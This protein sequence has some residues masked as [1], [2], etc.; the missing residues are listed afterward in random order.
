MSQSHTAAGDKAPWFQI[1][2]L[3]TYKILQIRFLGKTQIFV[4]RL[5]DVNIIA[6]D[7]PNTLNSTCAYYVGPPS[8]GEWVE[9]TC[10]PQTEGRFVKLDKMYSEDRYHLELCELEITVM[11]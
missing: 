9:I 2:L 8:M 10:S 1:D 5:H 4:D 7:T 6:G 3:K 11:I